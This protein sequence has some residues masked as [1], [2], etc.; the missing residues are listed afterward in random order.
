MMLVQAVP[1][2]MAPRH[3]GLT[4]TPAVGER[5]RCRPSRDFGSGAELA[6]MLGLSGEADKKNPV[7]SE[8]GGMLKG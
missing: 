3:S 5:S 2:F 8:D 1:K 4:C 7:G 6:V